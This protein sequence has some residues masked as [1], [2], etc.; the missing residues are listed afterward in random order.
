MAI[1]TPPA[2]P[3]QP[4][5]TP[6]TDPGPEPDKS[7]VPAHAAWV[8]AALALT[9]APFV[10]AGLYFANPQAAVIGGIIMGAITSALVL[11]ARVL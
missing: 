7:N 1:N 11:L 4:Q 9:E 8:G 2:Q 3:A 10:A 5:P 6:P